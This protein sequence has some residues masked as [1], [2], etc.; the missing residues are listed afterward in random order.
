MILEL[1]DRRNLLHVG[2]IATS[3]ED[4]ASLR[5]AVDVCR[6]NERPS[7]VVDECCHLDGD[8]LVNPSSVKFTGTRSTRTNMLLE[9]RLEHLDN[10]STLDIGCSEPLGPADQ[11]SM[12][13]LLLPGSSSQ[14]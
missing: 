10:V 11:Y 8:I 7:R 5:T 4:D 6:G 14:L 1:G 12:V 9:R 3:T 2:S 13:N